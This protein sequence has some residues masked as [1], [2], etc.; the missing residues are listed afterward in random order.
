M[1]LDLMSVLVVAAVCVNAAGIVFV[2]ETLLRRDE[3]AGRVWAVAFLAVMLSSLASLVWAQAPDAWWAV[4]VGNASFVAA[5][6]GIWLGCLRYNDR[7]IGWAGLV[8]GIAVVGA[9]ASVAVFDPAGGTGTG[10]LWMFAALV[11]FAGLAA[12]QCVRGDL[13][14]SRTAWLLAVALA[15]HTLYVISKTTAFLTSGPDSALFQSAFGPAQTSLVTVA[16]VVVAAIVL[17]V[18]RAARAPMRGYFRADDS[19]GDGMLGPAAF[20]TQFGDVC[21]RARSTGET[22]A[23]IAVRVDDLEQLSTAF[24]SEAA[25]A[26][27]ETVRTGVRRHA[28]AAALVCDDGPTGLLVGTVVTSE[29]EAKRAAARIYRGLFDDLAAAGAEVI[30]VVGVGLGLTSRDGDDPD[31]AIA[32][33]RAAASRAATSVDAA[34]L[35][36]D[37]E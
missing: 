14:E 24:G 33:A 26:V 9:A 13:R 18:V 17:S 16:L 29:G 37:A 8:V 35:V 2:I 12:V 4:A 28:P 11:L 19:G 5:A 27:T 25:R 6:G 21:T 32:A 1:V 7:R 34:V 22:V 3:G 15:L 31:A 36:G 10:E 30:P 20:R 23:V